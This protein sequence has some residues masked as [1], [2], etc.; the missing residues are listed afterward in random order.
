MLPRTQPVLPPMPRRTTPPLLHALGATGPSGIGILDEYEG[1]G[2]YLLWISLR[3]SELFTR[4]LGKVKF[5]SS[6]SE[7]CSLIDSLRVPEF[8]SIKDALHLLATLTTAAPPE[9]NAIAEG[10]E[11]IA[12]WS[13]LGSKLQTAVAYAQVASLALPA[14]AGYAVHTARLLRMRAEYVRA[15]SWFDHAI[16]LA[17][18]ENNWIVHAQA[19]SGLGCLYMQRGNLP[20]ARV[21]LHRSLR[22]AQRKK[23]AER[24]AAAFHNLFAVEAIA[25]HWEDAE[26]YAHRALKLYPEDARGLPR[27]ARDLAFRWM[28]RGYFERALPLA[29]E[30]LE[31]FHAPA[32]R[33]LA[34]SDIARAA[35][36]AGEFEDF[37]TAWA[38]AWVAVKTGAVEPLGADILL[39]LTHAAA[40]R[41]DAT[42]ATMAGREAIEV[43]RERKESQAVLEAEAMLDSLR[44][45]Q[46][47][48][49]SAHRDP[50]PHPL[51]RRFLHVLQLARAAR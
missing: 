27:L 43:A 33:A 11:L 32:E 37:E 47:A 48:A 2:G 17:K 19:Y 1:P 10:C 46:T 45:A 44:S 6:L 25:G 35:A 3:D 20:R 41:G 42:R 31:H 7:R 13:E 50:D 15:V 21:M 24:A 14:N 36:G 38:S 34:W 22:I 4:S 9:R 5:R 16:Y 8:D 30:A 18:V 26:R 51:S 23:L 28:Q 40:V 39:N 29:K 49:I 12:G